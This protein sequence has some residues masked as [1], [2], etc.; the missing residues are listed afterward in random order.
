MNMKLMVTDE[1]GD[2]I[3]LPSKWAICARCKGNG[4][5]GNPA[6]DGMSASDEFWTDDE[7][8]TENYIRGHFDVQCEAGCKD[9]KVRTLD[10]D[11]ATPEQV[12]LW[13][14]WL[15]EEHEARLE[16]EAEWRAGC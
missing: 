6:F 5:H 12:E 11:V 7:E 8:F 13:E 2:E 15:E 3:E 14:G 1:T 10:E 9:G 16:R 4:T